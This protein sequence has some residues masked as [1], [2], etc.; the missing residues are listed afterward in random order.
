MKSVQVSDTFDHCLKL[1]DL[2][3]WKRAGSSFLKPACPTFT[4]LVPKVAFPRGP[5]VTEGTG[6]GRSCGSHFFLTPQ[7]SQAI[8]LV[9]V[10]SVA[11]GKAKKQTCCGPEERPDRPLR[12]QESCDPGTA[13]GACSPRP[14]G[15]VALGKPLGRELRAPTTGQW[16]LQVGPPCGER[17]SVLLN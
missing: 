2:P 1:L 12:P 3:R 15:D 8:P 4:E 5:R 17:D 13:Q 11:A 16:I 9:S 10:A 7:E 6:L 14:A